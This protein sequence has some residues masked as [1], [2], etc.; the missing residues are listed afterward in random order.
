MRTECHDR[1]DGDHIFELILSKNRMHC[2]NLRSKLNKISYI[3]T[4]AIQVTAGRYWDSAR[5]LCIVLTKI[6][7]IHVKNFHGNR[8]IVVG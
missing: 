3:C 5:L 8:E 2:A 1:S 7:A 6:G 4:C